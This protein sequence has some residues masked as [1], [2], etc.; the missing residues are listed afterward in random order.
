MMKQ[1]YP[2]IVDL[3]NRRVAVIGGGKVAARK[4]EKL[5]AA[6]A[7]PT[8]ISPQLNPQ[9]ERQQIDWQPTTYRRELVEEMDMIW[10]CTDDPKVNAQVK[11]EATHFQLVNNTSDKQHS[12]FYNLAT[13]MVEDLLIGIST[14]G[15]SPRRAKQIKKEL[16]TWLKNRHGK[17]SDK[18]CI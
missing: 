8:V 15:T 5:V 13:V 18:P 2:L 9:I 11:A 17:E 6:G 4:I 16:I 10:A 12:D 3:T 7:R 1:P 14:Q